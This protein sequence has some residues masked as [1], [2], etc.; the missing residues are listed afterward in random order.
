MRL[1]KRFY[2]DR[3]LIGMKTNVLT[4]IHHKVFTMYNIF[5]TNTF[6]QLIWLFLYILHMKTVVS[7][8]KY[9]GLRKWGLFLYING[10]VK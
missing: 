1:L 8:D 2:F 4:Y 7:T 3:L 10:I 9:I 6:T 5:N